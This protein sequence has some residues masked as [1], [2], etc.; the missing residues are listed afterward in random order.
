MTALR[1]PSGAPFRRRSYDPAWLS[2]R[3][4]SSSIRWRLPT[5]S[6]LSAP[7]YYIYLYIIICL[8]ACLIS[9][10]ISF[11]II[12]ITFTSIVRVVLT[13]SDDSQMG[14]GVPARSQP[15]QHR[16]NA[17]HEGSIREDVQPDDQPNAT[18]EGDDATRTRWRQLQHQPE[19][20]REQREETGAKSKGQQQKLQPSEQRKQLPELCAT[21][22]CRSGEDQQQE[23]S[24]ALPHSQRP[25]AF[26]TDSRTAGA[27]VREVSGIGAMGKI[28]PDKAAC[29]QNLRNSRSPRNG[30][31][32]GRTA[33]R[34]SGGCPGTWRR[35]AAHGRWR[36]NIL[37]VPTVSRTN[38]PSLDDVLP[39]RVRN[40]AAE[41]CSTTT[42]WPHALRKQQPQQHREQE[43]RQQQEEDRPR[44]HQRSH[45]KTRQPSLHRRRP[46]SMRSARQPWKM[47]CNT[48]TRRSS[49]TTTAP[50][51]RSL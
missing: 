12:G 6:P 27:C 35:T 36:P 34:K 3:G 17:K 48:D 15:V 40:Q 22:A 43:Q 7:Q 28:M 5:P 46:R 14:K 39:A 13:F 26:C 25:P 42:G 21:A 20:P 45:R 33:E 11:I 23:K 16:P 44:H 30:M 47:R 41:D 49:R 29:M 38:S 10:S 2:P 32:E 18:D 1:A 31:Q 24:A 50:G 19:S 4:R 9:I 8:L 51:W 37:D